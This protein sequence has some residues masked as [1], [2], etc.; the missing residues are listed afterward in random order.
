MVNM[1]KGVSFLTALQ[2]V[3]EQR[4]QGFP[5][6]CIEWLHMAGNGGPG[7]L[8]LGIVM[9]A[10]GSRQP[11]HNHYGDEQI[12]YG[13]SGVSNHTVN[14][15][16]CTLYPG[17]WL[18]LPPYTTH[19]MSNLT[20]EETRFLMAANPC[21]HV[22]DLEPQERAASATTA[23]STVSDLTGQTNLQEI[24]NK[25]ASATGL[26]VCIVGPTGLLLT[27]P[28][29]MPEFCRWCILQQG[30]CEFLS[31]GRELDG[32]QQPNWL[33]CSYGLVALSIPIEVYGATVMSIVCGYVFLER[34]TPEQ[35]VAI[36]KQVS[37]EGH[38]LGEVVALYNG[39]E[40]VTKN[41]LISAAELLRVTAYS[42]SKIFVSAAR[43][44]EL[45]EYRWRL[46]HERSEKMMLEADLQR[47][48][49]ALIE[50][51]VNP[52][53]LFN[54]LNVI[55]ESTMVG[56]D[57]ATAELVYA[58]ADLL[59][60]SLKRI[61]RLVCLGEEIENV[62]NYLRIQQRRFPDCF[63]V[64]IDIPPQCLTHMI[65][66]VTL[67]PLVENYLVHGLTMNNAEKGLLRVSACQKDNRLQIIVEDNGRGIPAEKLEEIRGWLQLNTREVGHETG[68]RGVFWR[69][70]HYFHGQAA[71]QIQSWLGRG[72]RVTLSLPVQD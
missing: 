70:Q 43:E 8:S 41:R 58:L 7:T 49:V 61:G 22:K 30:G 67:Q 64:V 47:T 72:T 19:S 29:D 37:G 38:R 50:A 21:S 26:A 25:F 2:A 51:Q 69:L 66:A 35:A 34:P 11:P 39:V 60:F 24:Q 17:T 65:P 45:Q 44:R 13:I 5:W 33:K 9:V 14:G 3:N 54:T 28:A 18:Y 23:M 59:R 52:H 10:P 32:K 63:T 1:V 31:Q 62:R 36:C 16:S 46:L 53:F 68:I 56:G 6:G 42:L 15:S 12:L 48:R 4:R 20:K 40:L 27:E 71:L 55:A 57:G